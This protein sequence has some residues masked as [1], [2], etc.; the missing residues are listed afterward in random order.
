MY[1]VCHPQQLLVSFLQA[2]GFLFQKKFKDVLFFLLSQISQ[3]KKEKKMKIEIYYHFFLQG[4]RLQTRC[5]HLSLQ[6]VS[7]QACQALASCRGS[8]LVFTILIPFFLTNPTRGFLGRLGLKVVLILDPWY[9]WWQQWQQFWCSCPCLAYKLGPPLRRIFCWGKGGK[10]TIKSTYSSLS[11]RNWVLK[12][13]ES[14][15]FGGK[16]GMREF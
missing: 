12:V 8:L 11:S 9:W 15:V 4:F 14:I 6:E 1:Q 13:R 7:F 10:T 3:E 5:R 16:M 2:F